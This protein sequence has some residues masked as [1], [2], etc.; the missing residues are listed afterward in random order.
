MTLDE[1]YAALEAVKDKYEWK[2]NETSGLED[3]WPNIVG[4][5]PNYDRMLEANDE[6][7]GVP[8]EIVFFE[9]FGEAIAACDM[10][11]HE[12]FRVFGLSEEDHD[13]I[14]MATSGG[15]S[16]V[17]EFWGHEDAHDELRDKADAARSRML[18][19]LG[20][21]DDTAERRE[22]ADEERDEDL[23]DR[24]LHGIEMA[25][26]HREWLKS[27]EAEAVR[28]GLLAFMKLRFPSVP[29]NP[30]IECSIDG[31]A[32]RTIG[33]FKSRIAAAMLTHV[34]ASSGKA[35]FTHRV[36]NDLL[37]PH[38]CVLRDERVSRIPAVDKIA[39]DTVDAAVYRYIELVAKLHRSN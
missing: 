26:R 2:V 4:R 18:T 8:C 13:V 6:I 3:F 29:A 7:A 11:S 34:P 28:N 5:G 39:D 22:I 19:I 14:E 9:R 21:E 23:E 37:P 24:R 30:N 36:P 20:L 25:K 32:R 10:E 16:A 27:D 12:N 17:N 38:W 15:A 31:D 35:D 33:S 1:F